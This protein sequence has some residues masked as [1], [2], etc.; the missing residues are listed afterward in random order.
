MSYQKASRSFVGLH[1]HHSRPP[2][3]FISGVLAASDIPPCVPHLTFPLPTAVRSSVV[4]VLVL[5]GADTKAT[6]NRG[7][8]PGARFQPLSYLR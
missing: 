1:V 7:R 8:I 5:A 2:E 3:G 6:D 4:R